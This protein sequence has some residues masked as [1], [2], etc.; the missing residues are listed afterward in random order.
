MFPLLLL[1][2]KKKKS[3]SISKI[4]EVAQTNFSQKTL[5]M[6][7]WGSTTQLVPEITFLHISE[8]RRNYKIIIIHPPPSH[9]TPTHPPQKTQKKA[10]GTFCCKTLSHSLTSK[11]QKWHCLQ[12][13]QL[14]CYTLTPKVKFPQVP[15]LRKYVCITFH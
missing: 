6:C 10:P 11:Q 4:P 15:N 7:C 3:T 5:D 2:E 12:T 14:F 1:L 13:L 9:P 8:T